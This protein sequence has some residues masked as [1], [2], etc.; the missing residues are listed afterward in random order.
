LDF[1]YQAEAVMAQTIGRYE[2][3]HELGRGAQSVVF[4]AWDPW[5]LREVAIK[6]LHFSR[7]DVA[8]NH[9]L[10]TESRLVSQLR[11]PNVVQI[12]DT[13]EKDGNPYLVLERIEG[14]TLNQ[15]LNRDGPLSPLLTANLMRKILDALAHAH[16]R[17]II[18][19]DLK[20]SNI[21]I[22]S[23]GAPHVMDFGNAIRVTGDIDAGRSLTGTPAYMAPEYLE[24]REVSAQSDIYAAGL[25]M[26]ELLSGERAY[27]SDDV[28]QL[29][30]RILHEAIALPPCI[31]PELGK[32][33]RKAC[34]RDADQRFSSAVQMRDAVDDFLSTRSSTATPRHNRA[35]RLWTGFGAARG[36]LPR[37]SKIGMEH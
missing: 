14:H 23:A 33:I 2:I 18:H 9:L 36:L 27:Q 19:R 10:L 31:G 28:R 8:L 22:D 17:G 25:V 7:P 11:H 30:S 13:G 37:Y 4:L 5:L 12:F 3:R 35:A 29:H 32:M 6:T 1:D 15:C 24:K 16:E 26:Y 21:L 20:P 34:A